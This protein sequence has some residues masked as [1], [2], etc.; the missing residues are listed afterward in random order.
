[1]RLGAVVVVACVAATATACGLLPTSEE[2]SARNDV[3]A[4]GDAVAGYVATEGRLPRVK[5]I[6]DR[7]AS[8]DIGWGAD[9]LVESIRVPR[10]DPSRA[11]WFFVVGGA[12]EWCVEMLYNPPATFADSS[13]AEW[14]AARGERGEVGGVED[15]R[16]G[17]DYG[18]ILSPVTATDVPES[19]SFIDAVLAPAGTCLTNV[20]HDGSSTGSLEVVGCET[21]HFAEIYH[22]GEIDSGSY[23]QFQ[24]SAGE[25]CAEAFP[26]FVG[27]PSNLSA[28]SGEPFTVTEA[29][30][31]A[32]DRKFSCVLFLRSDDYPLVGSARNSWR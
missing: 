19:G 2:R 23:G 14:V 17:E 12:D 27:V 32:R 18:L 6:E 16:C 26:P 30:W 22:A 15:G 25:S 21:A 8:G 11:R 7:I 9:F 1:M 5:V 28:L 3:A 24:E 29:Q 4:V 13:P 10:A 20:L 31:Q